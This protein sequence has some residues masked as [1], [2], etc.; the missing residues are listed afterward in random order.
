MP[1]LLILNGIQFKVSKRTLDSIYSRKKFIF[2]WILSIPLS[3]HRQIKDDRDRIFSCRCTK[4]FVA[5]TSTE[6][7][8]H[9]QEKFEPPRIES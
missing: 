8:G 3:V 2:L 7:C 6:I 5:S 1:K 9:R 4:S